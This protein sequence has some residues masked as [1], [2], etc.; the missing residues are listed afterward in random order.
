MLIDFDLMWTPQFNLVNI[1]I[2]DAKNN[3]LNQ[4]EQLIQDRIKELG[5]PN[6]GSKYN[7]KVYPDKVELYYTVLNLLIIT[8]YQPIVTGNLYD[9]VNISINYK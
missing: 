7:Q 5:L 4:K 8:F 2:N 3:L 9:T 6:D 1:A